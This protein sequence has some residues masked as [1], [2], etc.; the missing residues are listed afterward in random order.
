MGAKKDTQEKHVNVRTVKLKVF[1]YLKRYNF[2]GFRYTRRP[3][4]NK[5]YLYIFTNTG[6]I[7]NTFKTDLTLIKTV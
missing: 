2:V 4:F 3:S 1:L 5:Q 6:N 7:W